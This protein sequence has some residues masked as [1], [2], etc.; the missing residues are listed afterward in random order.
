MKS[1]IQKYL[2]GEWLHRTAVL[3]GFP[4][5][6]NLPNRTRHEQIFSGRPGSVNKWNYYQTSAFSDRSDCERW[7]HSGLSQLLPGTRNRCFISVCVMNSVSMFVQEFYDSAWRLSNVSV[8]RR[9]KF[10]LENLVAKKITFAWS[11]RHWPS[12]LLFPS[13]ARD[14]SF[15][16]APQSVQAL[17]TQRMSA[18]SSSLG[19]CINICTGKRTELNF[20]MTTKP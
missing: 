6:T 8:K 17:I 9:L 13:D 3:I 14:A 20:S 7:Q 11:R 1:N 19:I 18:S 15:H 2:A 4:I 10:F 16:S 12:F 5:K